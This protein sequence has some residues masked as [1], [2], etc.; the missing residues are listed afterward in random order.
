MQDVRAPRLQPC[1][2]S[3]GTV[4]ILLRC[5]TA[6]PTGPFEHTVTDDW[7]GALTGDHVPTF[8]YTNGN[9]TSRTNARSFTTNYQYSNGT[10]SQIAKPVAGYTINRVINQEGTIARVQHQRPASRSIPGDGHDW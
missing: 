6:N 1:G 8:G 4:L 9:L 2:T 7:D 5:A 3:T 10:V